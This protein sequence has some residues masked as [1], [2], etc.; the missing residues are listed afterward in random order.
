MHIRSLSDSVFYWSGNVSREVAANSKWDKIICC[1]ESIPVS[2]IEKKKTTV[3]D[4][5]MGIG[6]K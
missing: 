4:W 5:I 6:Q 1:W 3:F 2:N